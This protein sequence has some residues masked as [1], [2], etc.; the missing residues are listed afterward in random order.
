MG[1]T[2]LYANMKQLNIEKSIGDFLV[3]NELK[4]NSAIV[5]IKYI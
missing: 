2:F 5:F 3:I 1:R 4:L